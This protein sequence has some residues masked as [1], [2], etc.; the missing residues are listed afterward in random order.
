MSHN[1]NILSHNRLW[2]KGGYNMQ[3]KNENIKC[4]VCDCEHNYHGKNCSLGT[5]KITCSKKGCTCCGDFT[6]K[7]E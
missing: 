1:N 5:V 3:N 7:P 2:L 4:D 6:E